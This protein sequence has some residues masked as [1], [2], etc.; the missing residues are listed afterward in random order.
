MNKLA[1]IGAVALSA[2]T[3]GAA[4]IAQ[5]NNTTS[6]FVKYDSNNDGVITWEEAYG[7]YPTLT[8]NIFDQA[9][10]NGDGVL[11][12]G[13]FTGLQGLTAGDGNEATPSSSEESS[14]VPDDESSSEEPGVPEI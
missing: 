13:E 1:I 4:A 14:S 12:E 2:A 6:D 11:D 5:D 9:D 7:A 3:F 8:Q 10:A